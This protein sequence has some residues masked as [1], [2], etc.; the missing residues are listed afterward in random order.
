MPS[1]CVSLH[2]LSFPTKFIATALFLVVK[3]SRP[4]TFN[5]L[6]VPMLNSVGGNETIKQTLFKTKEK[7]GFKSL[8]LT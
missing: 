5:Y 7:N 2:D 1:A 3:S 8:I 4:T 6:M